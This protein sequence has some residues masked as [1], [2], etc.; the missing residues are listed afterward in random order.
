MSVVIRFI[1]DMEVHVH[2]CNKCWQEKTYDDWIED[3]AICT[4]CGDEE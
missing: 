2:V 1:D 3:E 4:G